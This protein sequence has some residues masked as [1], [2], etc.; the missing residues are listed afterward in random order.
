MNSTE[1]PTVLPFTKMHGL[2]NDFVLL[3]GTQ[4]DGGC[5]KL[6]NNRGGNNGGINA[7]VARA[8]GDR[9]RGIGF[10]Q[11]L[12]AL[13][14]QSEG[15]DVRMRIVNA[16][17][18]EAGQCGNGLRCFARFVR[19]R[20]IVRED[21]FRIDTP[22]GVA[23]ARLESLSGESSGGSPWAGSGAA[24]VSVEI[25]PPRFDPADIPFRVPVRQRQY[26]LNF[27]TQTVV[28]VEDTDGANI[29]CAGV[30]SMGNPHAVIDV[31]DVNA[32]DVATVGPRV[33]SFPVFPDGVNV[34]FMERISREEI[35][36][37]V[38]ERGAGETLAC[39]SGACAAVAVG[40]DR[41][42]L[43]AS[44]MVHLPGGAL[45]ISWPSAKDAMLM[46]G[47]A[48]KVFEGVLNLEGV[49]QL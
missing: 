28:G 23:L 17:G 20:G 36:L 44:V 43:E 46:R 8:I 49:T 2:G 21:E 24:I 48:S 12:I 34:G 5:A 14:P 31:D 16:D 41:G 4:S 32:I 33:Q 42:F 39:G 35:R 18:S 30:V 37:R 13:P 9:H 29:V 19:E 27:D 47:P 1:N 38:F 11:L 25:P 40:R 7:E 6:G 15:A 26:G 3:D 22:G 10:D 45:E